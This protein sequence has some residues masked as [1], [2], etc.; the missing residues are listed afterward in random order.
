MGG[1]GDKAL[2]VLV[3]LFQVGKHLI[4]GSCEHCQFILSEFVRVGTR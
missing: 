4:K 3:Q 1:M 2:S